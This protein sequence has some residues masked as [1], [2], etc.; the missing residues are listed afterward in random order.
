MRAKQL[1]DLLPFDIPTSQNTK[2]SVKSTYSSISISEGTVLYP[3]VCPW[4]CLVKA[5]SPTPS[6]LPVEIKIIPVKHGKSKI[7]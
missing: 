6:L 1:Q 7:N 4:F 3:R 2:N 5:P